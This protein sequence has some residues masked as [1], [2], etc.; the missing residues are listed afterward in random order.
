M[1]LALTPTEL[2]VLD[3]LV[4]GK[5]NDEIAKELYVSVRTVQSHIVHLSAKR[6]HR[7]RT[8]AAVY[9]VREVIGQRLR[10]R[11]IADDVIKEALR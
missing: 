5:R 11:G 9:R 4:D 7:N 6:G 3:M 1:S 10:E 8:E 2:Q